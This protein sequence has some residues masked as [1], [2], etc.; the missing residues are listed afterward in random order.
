MATQG[1]ILWSKTAADNDNSDSTVNWAE[2]QAPSTVNN[3]ARAEMA[4]FARWRDDVSGTLSTG[5]TSTAYTV[6]TNATFN[7]EAEMDGAMITVRIG[8][9]NGAS[10]TLAADGLT[11][12]A[13]NTATSTAVGAGALVA[14]SVHTLTFIN[15]STEWRL[16]SSFPLNIS[17]L[18]AE[19]AV[20]V[21]DVFPFYDD[22]AGANRKVTVPNLFKAVSVLDAETSVDDD[23]ILLICDASDSNAANRATLA[24]VF[25]AVGTLPSETAIATGDEVLIID[26]SESGAANRMTITDLFEAVNAFTEDT[27]PDLDDDFVLTYDA[28]AST[29][30]KVNPDKFIIENQTSVADAT[31]SQITGT[32]PNDDSIPQSGEGTEVTSG[33]ITPATTSHKVRIRFSGAVSCGTAD[34]TIIVALFRSGQANALQVTATAAPSNDGLAQV[35]LEYVDS[36]SSSSSVTYSIRAG[37]GSGAGVMFFGAG[38]SGTRFYGGAG[39]TTLSL[40][41]INV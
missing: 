36:P 15:A 24:N 4:S 23:D 17:G 39:S 41:Q 14:G 40:E 27:S 21:A 6:T 5:G 32:I 18:T 11:A 25:K 31:H 34:T 1:A 35:Y 20:A 22:S 28:S 12:R 37:T 3:S 9:T 29:V 16:H 38:S 7:T 8:T 2:G 13:I 26:A 30:K 19:T 10:V 33:S